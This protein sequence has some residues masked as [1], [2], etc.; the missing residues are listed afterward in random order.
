MSVASGVSIALKACMAEI[1]PANGF[2]T[3]LKQVYGP[4][5]RV[6]DKAPMPYALVRPASDVRTGA[7]S[8]Q[9][10]RQRTYEIEVVFSRGATE[11]DLDAVHVDV[12]R[13]LGF[14]LD[15]YERKFPGLIE[16]EDSAEPRFASE[17]ETTHSITI[18]IGVLYVEH[19]N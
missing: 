12:L 1:K 18:T 4:T 2:T 16:D 3:D 7:A 9:A 11:S 15:L 13:A 19:Y 17:G 10:T 14:G 5:E 8:F 6:R